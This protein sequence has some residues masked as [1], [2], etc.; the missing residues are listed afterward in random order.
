MTGSAMDCAEIRNTLLG[1]SVPAGPAVESHVRDCAPCS[2]LLQNQAALGRKLSRN[3]P[4][5]L[6]RRWG[7]GPTD[8]RDAGPLWSSIDSAISADSGPRAWLRSRKTWVRVILA[9]AVGAVIVA[10][11]GQSAAEFVPRA[12][13]VTWLVLFS[14]VG[15]SCLWVLVAPLGRPRPA[16]G[17][18]EALAWVALSLPLAYALA[19]SRTP[20]AT[21]GELGFAEQAFACFAYGSV[22]A[23]PF[24]VVVWT[25]D[26]SDRPRLMLLA[27]M[28]GVAGLV[29]NSALALHC[30]NTSPLHLAT[31]HATI[32]AALAGIG[33]LWALGRTK[34]A[35]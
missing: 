18:R 19:S 3:E 2:E 29:A 8:Q 30:P 24:L 15:L 34:S 35:S 25:L 10:V 11:G 23:L 26:R 9:T 13:A 12:Q 20:R 32:G 27:G 22:L 28:A 14:L 17:T 1:G 5:E 4:A 6:D 33:A 21:P 31:G 16:A 7:G